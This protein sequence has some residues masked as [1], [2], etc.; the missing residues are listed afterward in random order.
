MIVIHLTH[1]SARFAPV[2]Y[3]FQRQG[4]VRVALGKQDGSDI[5]NDSDR[6][7]DIALGSGAEDFNK[8]SETAESVV[9][10]LTCPPEQLANLTAPFISEVAAQE[11]WEMQSSDF[12]YTPT[13]PIQVAEEIELKVNDLIEDLESDEDTLRV[14]TSLGQ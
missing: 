8:I 14:W 2:K 11:P 13:E 5:V 4:A 7:L 10:Q 3:L 6:L 9:F 1:S 12:M